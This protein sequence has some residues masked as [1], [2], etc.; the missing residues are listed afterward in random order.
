[1]L[2]STPVQAQTPCTFDPGAPAPKC[3]AV[4]PDGTQ[5]WI[6]SY[7][8]SGLVTVVRLSDHAVVATIPV[9]YFPMDIAISP[10]GA[11]A[12]VNNTVDG[13]YTTKIATA[14]Y[15]VVCNIPG[16]TD[17]SGIAFPP[18]GDTGIIVANWTGILQGIAV[19][20][21]A[22]SYTIGGL[23]AGCIDAVVTPDG[24]YAYATSTFGP[25]PW[26]VFKV[27][28]K[29][30]QVVDF[31]PAGCGD[32]DITPDGA[33]LFITNSNWSNYVYVVS[34]AVDSLIDSIYVGNRC[35]GV[36]VS[37]DG[38]YAYVSR[39]GDSSLAVLSV[40]DR[41]VLALLPVGQNPQS[42][43]VS[44]DGM[45]IFVANMASDCITEI[46]IPAAPPCLDR[47]AD[48]NCDK[49]EDVF[50]VIYLIDYVFSGG[51][52]RVPCPQE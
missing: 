28:L 4:T 19:D 46:W 13:Y 22:A 44:P 7:S 40:A 41:S 36:K 25:G 33:L 9:G 14:T 5:L 45:W 3:L 32:L 16:G 50:D 10:D 35:S 15:T 48:L 6:G 11:Y 47:K 42:I 37:P 23:G 29:A 49:V 26:G 8:G 43:A 27:D 12:F 30:R 52:P 38:L 39:G 51:P 17:P 21:C 31:L 18:V 34:T 2:L 1:M 24:K 20:D